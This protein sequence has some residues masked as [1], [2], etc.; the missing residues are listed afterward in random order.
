MFSLEVS[1]PVEVGQSSL[2]QRHSFLIMGS[3]EAKSSRQ[4]ADRVLFRAA[5]VMI[6][7]ARCRF[8]GAATPCEAHLAHRES[9]AAGVLRRASTP[10]VTDHFRRRWRWR[11]GSRV[12]R[13]GRSLGGIRRLNVDTAQP[14]AIVTVLQVPLHAE[15]PLLAPILSP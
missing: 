7:A 4:I 12:W 15:V 2:H 14:K 1:C 11:S 8:Q 9:A 13:V 3:L 10:L 5:V 6:I